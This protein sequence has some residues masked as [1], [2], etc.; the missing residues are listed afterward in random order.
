MPAAPLR[1]VTPLMNGTSSIT[2]DR[3]PPPLTVAPD[4]A[5]SWIDLGEH[6]DDAAERIINAHKA[7]G[8]AFD[9]PVMNLATWGVVPV[10]GKF[11]LAPLG[12]QHGPRV[13]RATAFSNLMARY[14]APAEFI[15][16]RLPAPL[17]LAVTNWLTTAGDK[18]SPA[19]LRLRGDEVAAVVSDRYAPLD[20]EPL[21]DCVRA[22][23]VERNAL[24][25]VE[26]KSIATGVTDVI[27]L[28]FPS[29]QVPV[30]VGDVSALGLDISSS[31]FG[32]SAVHVRGLVL[33]LRC[34]NGL[35]VAEATGNFSFRHVGDVQRL[36]ASISEAI[37]SALAVARGTL[38]KWKA[39]VNVMVH[40][41]A[42][43]ISEVQDLTAG[44]RRL[45]EERVQIETGMPKLPERA[46]LYD[47]L[48]GITSA[49][50]AF[51]PARRL[52]V[53]SVAGQLLSSRMR[54]P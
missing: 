32:R 45:V 5:S 2:T 6:F 54:E 10:E 37:P 38:G 19:M 27:R 51:I 25:E 24:D 43:L 23:L 40:D 36:R 31:S 13:L 29:E 34:L 33:R 3:I 47:V 52:E 4:M 17:Q 41:V 22:A 14:G 48:N 8:D 42:A 20:Q 28:V 12:R 1:R 44:E 53:E 18:A 50:H 9:Q 21:L 11:A 26:V 46:P 49:A 35:R 7:D 16:D 30:K 39:A 15:R